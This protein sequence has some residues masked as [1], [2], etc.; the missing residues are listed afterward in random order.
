MELVVICDP[1]GLTAIIY[2]LIQRSHHKL[3]KDKKWLCILRGQH[4]EQ[5]A[6]MLWKRLALWV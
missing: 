2:S 5:E 4:L 1:V 3:G 6:E